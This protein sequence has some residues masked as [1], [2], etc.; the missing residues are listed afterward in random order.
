MI[1]IWSLAAATLLVGASPSSDQLLAA[2]RQKLA[3]LPAPPYVVF[4]YSDVRSGPAR[5]V[6]EEH[7]VYRTAAGLERNA[8]LSINGTKVTPP[9]VRVLHARAFPY[10]VG[11]FAVDASLY[12]LAYAGRTTVAGKNVFAFT[13][14][15]RADSAFAI[16]GLYLD[17]RE[18]LPVR[19]T[20]VARSSACA[21]TGA[22]DFTRVG[23]YW[24]VSAVRVSCSV[25][26]GSGAA[27]P[28]FR[29]S[30][31]FSGYRFPSAF[32]PQVFGGASSTTPNAPPP[33]S[34]GPSP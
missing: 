29:E 16:D 21:G 15:R 10:D 7:E 30:L 4:A 17:A 14:K 5:V 19:E 20:F 26:R 24:L 6:A 11:K 13:A 25:A 27:G 12:D 33:S 9:R 32:P 18:L 1:S 34:P 2:Y 31:R 3:A 22:I 28:T 23:K 8:I